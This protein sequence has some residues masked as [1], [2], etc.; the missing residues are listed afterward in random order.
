MHSLNPAKSSALDS[1]LK[2]LTFLAAYRGHSSFSHMRFP[3]LTPAPTATTKLPRR[4]NLGEQKP[5]KTGLRSPDGRCVPCSRLPVMFL[6]KASL[7]FQH[8]TQRSPT[9]LYN[10]LPQLLGYTF[11]FSSPIKDLLEKEG[12]CH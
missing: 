4:R 8:Y 2:T 3:V 9:V 1:F 5:I 12:V 11:L 10:F 6:F 7:L